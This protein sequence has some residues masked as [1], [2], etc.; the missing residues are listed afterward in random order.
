[1]SRH[2]G[3]SL[4]SPELLRLPD[5]LARVDALIF[6]AALSAPFAWHFHLGDRAAVPGGAPGRRSVPVRPGRRRPGQRA[7]RPEMAGQVSD[8]ALVLGWLGG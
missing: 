1:M 4:L 2:R 6:D 3:S 7:E 8:P 5:E